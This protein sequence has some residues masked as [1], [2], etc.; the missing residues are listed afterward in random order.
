MHCRSMPCPDFFFNPLPQPCIKR[1]MI[2]GLRHCDHE[3][4]F[5]H[6][7]P[8][9]NV[10][11]LSCLKKKKKNPLWKSLDHCYCWLTA[12]LTEMHV[13]DITAACLEKPRYCVKKKEK[14]LNVFFN[15]FKVSIR[16]WFIL[17]EWK[18]TII[19]EYNTWICSLKLHSENIKL[20]FNLRGYFFIP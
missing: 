11:T 12:H 15:R 20:H 8:S 17:V 13:F 3:Q 9:F 7:G 18:S 16:F 14:R 6:A 2:V 1:L 5:S 4:S 19:L 10:L